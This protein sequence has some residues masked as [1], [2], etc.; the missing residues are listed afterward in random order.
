MFKKFEPE[1]SVAGDGAEK[2]QGEES[3]A[4][5]ETAVPAFGRE[6]RA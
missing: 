5:T 4:T 1:S 3:P 2:V 6:R